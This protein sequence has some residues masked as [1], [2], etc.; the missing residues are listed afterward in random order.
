LI[1]VLVLGAGVS[2]LT[3][4]L[5]LQEQGF[6]VEIW[7]AELAPNAST[8]AAAFWYPFQVSPAD[9]P[10]IGKWAERSYHHLLKL[11]QSTGSGVKLRKLI[12]MKR[13]SDEFP[14]WGPIVPSLRRA[15][16]T[17]ITAP[18]TR[19]LCV[20][21]L[22][23]IATDM[24]LGWLRKQYTDAGGILTQRTVSSI[25]EAFH[26]CKLVINCTGLGAR[27]LSGEQMQPVRGQIMRIKHRGQVQWAYLDS[28]DSS[29]LAY[30]VP[31]GD[32]SCETDYVVLGG[33]Y[34][35]GTSSTTPDPMEALRIIQRCQQLMP[36]L[37]VGPEDI[38]RS[39]CGLR[40][41]RSTILVEARRHDAGVEILNTG[42]GGAGYTLAQGCAE[43]AV[44]LL[45]SI[46]FNNTLTKCP[47][48]EYPLAI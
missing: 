39:S 27:E 21:R 4:A 11:A 26:H 28:D 33:T 37:I 13:E 2:G 30:I 9:R 12:E 20:E 6:K 17:E 35:P 16:A 43:D 45:K 47:L 40:P 1:D 10:R 7:Y 3:T 46:A 36:G 22:P 42:H 14:W 5:Q 18:Y 41:G 31:H 29:Q 8:N 34:E 24:H 32:G 15:R 48:I 19:A 44:E 23:V 25:E 38:I